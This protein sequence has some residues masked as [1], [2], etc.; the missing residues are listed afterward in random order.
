VAVSG[1]AGPTWPPDRVAR[2][3]LALAVPGEVRDALAGATAHLRVPGTELRPTPPAGWHVTVAFLGEVDPAAAV[4]AAEVAAA[5]LAVAAPAPAPELVVRRAGRFGD[6]VLVAHLGE[7]PAGALEVVVERLHAALGV[8]GLTLPDR[9]F[10]PH[11]TLARA[12]GARRVTRRDAATL[13]LP[14]GRWRPEAVGL[15]ATAPPGGP[16]PYVV[17]SVLPWPG[18]V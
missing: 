15:W 14:P 7:E 4:L 3:F 11:L 2:R 17:E 10:R 8:A 18:P 5:T 12:R 13:R 6:R 9:A 1:P 16:H